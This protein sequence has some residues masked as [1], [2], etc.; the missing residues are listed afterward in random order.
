ME[1][2]VEIEHY[3]DSETNVDMLEVQIICKNAEPYLLYARA[4]MECFTRT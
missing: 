1:Y 4:A 2:I 3:L